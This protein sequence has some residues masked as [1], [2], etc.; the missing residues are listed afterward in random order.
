MKTYYLFIIAFLHL[1]IGNV[2]AQSYSSIQK[3]QEKVTSIKISEIS[4]DWGQVLYSLESPYPGTGIGRAALL[5]LKDSLYGNY[6]PKKIN[7]TS[8]KSPVHSPTNLRNFQG[9]FHNGIPNDND[10]AISN[11]G[12]LI[13]VINSVFTIW[14]TNKDSLLATVSLAALAQPLNLPNSKYDPKVIYD[15]EADK[16]VMIFLNGTTD[17]TSKIILAY[18]ETS[19]PTGTWNLYALEGNPINNNTWSDYPVVGIS[20]HELFIGI[21]TFYNGSSNNSGF[22]ETCFWQVSLNEGYQGIPLKTEYYFNI[23]QNNKAIFNITPMKGGSHTYGPNMYLISNRNLSAENDT[24]FLLEVTDT[25]DAPNKQFNIKVL[26]SSLM[27]KIPPVARQGGTKKF[28]TNDSRVL[29]GFY[30]NGKIQFVQSCLHSPTGF[31][32]IFHGTIENLTGTPTI[33]AS[34]IGDTLLD[35]GFPNISYT[36]NSSSDNSAIITC[37]HTAPTIFAGISAIQYDGGSYFSEVSRIMDGLGYVASQSGNMQRWGDYTGSQRKYNEPGKVW[38]SGYYGTSSRKN[39]TWVAELSYNILSSISDVK[40]NKESQL[41]AF[42]N[43][44][45]NNIQIEFSLEKEEV[46]SFE[47]IDF[48]GRIVKHLLTERC[49]KGTNMIGFS[50]EPLPSGTYFL[51]STGNAGTI[52]TQ[53]IIRR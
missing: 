52:L 49:K 2:K 20:K 47:I 13:S 19:D 29:G 6:A 5:A 32:G 38:M 10:L 48:N 28:D 24:I 50:I 36:G 18:S 42:P 33:K 7:S 26:K 31:A 8:P 30:E 46:M 34:I 14:D 43:P 16:F 25:I 21:N 37:N 51:K 44:F 4:E 17:T 12:K 27:Y 1:S 11:D 3:K 45:A 53:K 39:A 41:K 23:L 9:N 35:L 22:V 15:P 40:P